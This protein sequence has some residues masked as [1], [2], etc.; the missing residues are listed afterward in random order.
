MEHQC[1]PLH[2][3][4]TYVENVSLYLVEINVPYADFVIRVI[5]AAKVIR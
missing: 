2:I 1:I 5:C 3:V 4:G